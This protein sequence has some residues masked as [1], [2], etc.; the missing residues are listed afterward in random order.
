M[1]LCKSFEALH[2]VECATANSFEASQNG[3]V[4]IWVEIVTLQVGVETTRVDIIT[5]QVRVVAFRIGFV[6]SCI[7]I[8]LQRVDFGV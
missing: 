8:D 3:A 4:T 6:A 2:S 7:G 1:C 5:L